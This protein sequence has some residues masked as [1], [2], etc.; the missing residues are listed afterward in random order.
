MSD[1]VRAE[2]EA[3]LEEPLNASAATRV[4]AHVAECAACQRYA[5]DLERGER[6]LSLPEP[7]IDPPARRARIPRRSGGAGWVLAA[8]LTV[9]LVAALVGTATRAD[10]VATPDDSQSSAAPTSALLAAPSTPAVAAP[11]DSIVA[12]TRGAESHVIVVDQRPVAS[13]TIRLEIPIV[14]GSSVEVAGPD[15]ILVLDPAPSR[16]LREFSASTGRL[17]S[18]VDVG[19]SAGTR[20]ALLAVSAD[21]KR[22]ATARLIGVAWSIELIDLASGAGVARA[23]LGDC[24]RPVAT[25]AKDG[26]AMVVGCFG[27]SSVI[28]AVPGSQPSTLRMS[29]TLGGLAQAGDSLYAF[30]NAGQV[31]RIGPPL[32][33]V[34]RIGF[35]GLQPTAWAVSVVGDRIALGLHP[36]TGPPDVVDRVALFD[37]RQGLDLGPRSLHFNTGGG[38]VSTPSMG[39]VVLDP[40]GSFSPDGQLLGVRADGTLFGD[41]VRISGPRGERVTAVVGLVDSAGATTADA[42]IRVADLALEGGRRDRVEAIAAARLDIARAFPALAPVIAPT[43]R[44]STLWVVAEEGLLAYRGAKYSWVV[45]MVDPI[46]GQV[47]GVLG[48]VSGPRPP[49]FDALPR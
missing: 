29:D 33:S 6:L 3:R 38:L 10:L 23:E 21:T 30:G 34:G 1:H 9:V 18:A 17:V 48:G 28:S 44:S 43:T 45:L 47:V 37:A 27:G 7:A 8:C 20:S 36:T 5:A 15:R 32:S 39:G 40:H 12:I 13:G 22:A 11:R 24:D 46:A 14:S 2:L 25:I 42:A 35:E 31:W 16:R 41:F 49:A 4:N 19:T 26:A